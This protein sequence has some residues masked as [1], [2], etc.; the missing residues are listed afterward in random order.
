[1]EKHLLDK[2]EADGGSEADEWV[3][4]VEESFFF[5]RLSDE[6]GHPGEEGHVAQPVR[7]EV[8][9]VPFGKTDHHTG[10]QGHRPNNQSSYKKKNNQ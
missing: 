7:D 1:M 4:G 6:D 3:N 9:S 2:V 10:Q 8:G 5:V